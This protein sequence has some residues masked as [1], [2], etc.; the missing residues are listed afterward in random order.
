MNSLRDLETWAEPLLAR[1]SP[2]ERRRLMRLIATGLRRRQRE[3]IKAQRDPDGT[4]FEPRKPQARGQRG[5]VRR[6]PMFTKI[7]QVKHLRTTG[8]T[9]DA[10]RLGFAG[11]IAR[12]ARVHQYGERDRVTPDGPY[13]DYPARELLGFSEADRQWIREMLIQHLTL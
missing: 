9:T 11:R 3:R 2:Q 7:R 6:S 13:Y 10:A 5:F 12:I 1:L 4:P 8:T